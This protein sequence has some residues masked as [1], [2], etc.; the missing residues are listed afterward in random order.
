MPGAHYSL[1]ELAIVVVALV[2][3]RDLFR[4]NRGLAAAGTA[5][6]GLAAAIGVVR[7]A[8]GEVDALAA[9]H[10]LVS[11]AGGASAMGLIAL[12][13]AK[14]TGLAENPPRPLIG[15]LAV[16]A[17]VVVALANPA[18]ATPLFLFWLL[19]ATLLAARLPAR[20]AWQRW[21]RSAAVGSFVLNVLLVR[22]SLVLGPDLSWHLFHVLVALW[23]FALWRVFAGMIELELTDR[24]GS[25]A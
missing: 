21:L 24:S 6:L 22:Q 18:L 7:F 17:T 11:Q 2:A 12:Q 1:S 23:L 3:A 4:K 14:L 13:L 25:P 9:I 16:L 8:N 10:K 15:A 19:A 20:A 5:I